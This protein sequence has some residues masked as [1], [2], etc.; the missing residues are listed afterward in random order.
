[1][2]RGRR[3]LKLKAHA[4]I[5]NVYYY[6]QHQHQKLKPHTVQSI[7]ELYTSSKKRV[8]LSGNRKGHMPR[9]CCH[10]PSVA[11]IPGAPCAL[12]GDAST[13]SLSSRHPDP[14]SDPN[15][16]QN[17]EFSDLETRKREGTRTNPSSA[18]TIS[19][20]PEGR[21]RRS[22]ASQ[23]VATPSSSQCSPGIWSRKT[24]P[25]HSSIQ[26]SFGTLAII[27]IGLSSIPPG[28]SMNNMNIYEHGGRFKGK[29]A[30]RVPS[31]KKGRASQEQRLRSGPVA[32][33]AFRTRGY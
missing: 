31:L 2:P 26:V 6:V 20:S 29:G 28:I 10:K 25:W 16:V 1:M 15:L 30:P 5:R 3:E 33:L 23:R 8:W 4:M 13:L 17:F 18:M 32:S 12:A 11:R 27:R 19:S 9:H 14:S 7:F 22:T 24:T 21:N